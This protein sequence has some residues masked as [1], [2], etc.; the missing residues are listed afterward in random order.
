MVM[1]SEAVLKDDKGRRRNIPLAQLSPE[2]K[3]YIGLANPPSLAI[4][5]SRKNRPKYAIVD[6]GPSGVAVGYF[7]TY[8]TKL[9]QTSAG[10]Y[11]YPLDVEFFAIGKE[12]HGDQYVLLNRQSSRFVLSKENDRSHSFSG[13]A[14][15]LPNYILDGIHRGLKDSGCLV[16][17]TD[18]RGKIIEYYSSQKWLFEHVDNLK[19]LS[20]G[21]Y[22]DKSCV[23]VYPTGPKRTRY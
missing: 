8:K 3:K 16:V 22:M 2:D 5:F 18:P 7:Y 10:P 9:K 21:N 1:G 23:R 11:P 17:V 13:E 4:S 15:E 12:I 14:V 6:G 19:D 20:I